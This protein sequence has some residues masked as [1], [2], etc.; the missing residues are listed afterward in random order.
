[1]PVSG[2]IFK[3]MMIAYI[4]AGIKEPKTILIQPIVFYKLFH[5]SV[6]ILDDS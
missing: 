6:S 5:W 2:I 3:I 1:M 4:I